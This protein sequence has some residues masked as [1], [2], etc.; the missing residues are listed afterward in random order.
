MSHMIMQ[1]VV[2]NGDVI[3]RLLKTAGPFQERVAEPIAI[4]D[5]PS[6]V[7]DACATDDSIQNSRSISVSDDVR[8]TR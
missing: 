5:Y 2:R 3:H 7:T 6:A 8:S 1:P 4:Q